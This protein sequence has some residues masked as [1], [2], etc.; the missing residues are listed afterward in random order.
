MIRVVDDALPQHEFHKL[1]NTLDLAQF[2]DGVMSS[3]TGPCLL[4]FN[5]AGEYKHLYTNS[6]RAVLRLP[7]T[8][9]T[10]QFTH[11]I[12]AN[13]SIKSPYSN[14]MTPILDYIVDTHF[15]DMVG[16]D[17]YYSRI[18]INLL[19]RNHLVK[20][21]SNYSYP[22]LDS[23]DPHLSMLLYLNKSDGD[24]V[25]FKNR[26]GERDKELVEEIRVSPKPNRVVM[27]DGHYHAG[28]NP[29]NYDIRLGMNV[30][31]HHSADKP[32]E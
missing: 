11:I 13:S 20:D 5:L 8:V 16:G 32:I 27:S 10:M 19:M 28:T 25:F 17:Y 26:E 24:T 29:M 7:N 15:L 31:L 6:P 21:K 3:F 2:N 22:H 14:Y 9:D 23:A 30:V 12:L 1:L 18:K 4:D